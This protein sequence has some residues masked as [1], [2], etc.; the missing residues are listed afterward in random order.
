M[1]GH[2]PD[3][4]LWIDDLT[5]F[6]SGWTARMPGPHIVMGHSMGGHLVLRALAERRIDP[7]AAVLI[8]PMLG[9]ETGPLP[10]SWVAGLVRLLA[11]GKWQTRSAWKSNERP[12]RPGT[13]RQGFL[14]HDANRY[15]DEV[16]WKS[17][18]PELALGPPS[19]GWLALAYSSALWL[20]REA[21]LE[22]ITTPMTIIGTDGDKLV[23]PMAIRRIAARLPKASLHM[24]GPDVAHEILRERDVPRDV[25]LTLI[26]SQLAAAAKG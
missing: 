15:A 7:A 3:F 9:F 25:A 23:S 2:C 18:K 22:A 17:Q 21:K 1:V 5:E 26:D 8:A 6:W 4:G 16:W 20:Q 19:I 10:L 12:S 14:T 13:S 24:F 11:K